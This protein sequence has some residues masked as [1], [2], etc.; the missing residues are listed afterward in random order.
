MIKHVVSYNYRY[1]LFNFIL[2]VLNLVY[3]VNIFIPDRMAVS[4]KK[5]LDLE[6]IGTKEEIV[7][8]Q[9][10]TLPSSTVEDICTVYLQE[11]D[12]KIENIKGK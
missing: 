10:E 2:P 7:S 4:I 12:V 1:K 11:E 3:N 5:E 9:E 6:E 8:I